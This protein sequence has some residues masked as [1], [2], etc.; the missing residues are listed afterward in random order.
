MVGGPGLWPGGQVTGKNSWGLLVVSG[1]FFT[2]I[3]QGF[4]GWFSVA[5]L[6]LDPASGG[7]LGICAVF[8]R[9]GG[10]WF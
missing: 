9:K 7:L 6:A 10:Y 3:F 5:F 2:L 8:E 1:R 4:W